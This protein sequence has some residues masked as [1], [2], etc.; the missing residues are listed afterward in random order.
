M[1]NQLLKSKAG[2]SSTRGELTGELIQTPLPLHLIVLHFFLADE[3]A[4]ALLCV[5]YAADL[6]LA[7]SP[8]YGVRIDRK[9][10]CEL[11]YGAVD[12]LA[13][14]TKLVDKVAEWET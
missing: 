9:I 14:L 11:P 2:C 5:E 10:H 13:S 4:S 6:E 3:C 12:L 1:L 7:V 8:Q